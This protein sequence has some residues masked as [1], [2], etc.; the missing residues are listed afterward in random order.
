MQ[1][2]FLFKIVLDSSCSSLF[3]FFVGYQSVRF[4]VWLVC[5]FPQFSQLCHLLFHPH[6][7]PIPFFVVGSL[8]YSLSFAR[9]FRGFSM[10]Y[11]LFCLVPAFSTRPV[12]STGLH[13]MSLILL[14]V[15]YLN[16]TINTCCSFL[17]SASS[18]RSFELSRCFGLPS[19]SSPVDF[20]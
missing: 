3:Y 12:D 16:A 15:H 7:H 4:F 13:L 8:L 5:Y 10:S 19:A 9:F 14:E 1:K 11:W 17:V 2:R 20:S 18:C 6:M